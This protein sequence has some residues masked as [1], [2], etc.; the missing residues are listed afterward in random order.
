MPTIMINF[1]FREMDKE[2]ARV[3]FICACMDVPIQL[4]LCL[5]DQ[6]DSKLATYVLVSLLF[7]AVPTLVLNI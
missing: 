5:Y 3:C 4:K 2:F 7:I 6:L 1:K